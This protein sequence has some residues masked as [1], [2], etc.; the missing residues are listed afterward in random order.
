MHN[1]SAIAEEVNIHLDLRGRYCR[2]FQEHTELTILATL[3]WEALLRKNIKKSAT[4]CYLQW[5]LNW[6]PLP[7]HMLIQLS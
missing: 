5:A 7:F 3:T 1:D 6:G 4:K 2:V